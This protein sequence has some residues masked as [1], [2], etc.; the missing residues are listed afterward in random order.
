MTEQAAPK[1]LP[2]ERIA[3]RLPDW[4]RGPW[5][6]AVALV[7]GV[8]Q[9]RVSMLARQAAYSLL[10]AVPSIVILAVSLANIID[11]RTGSHL[12]D[13][14]QEVI[15]EHAPPEFQAFLSDILQHAL[16]DTSTDAATTAAIVAILIAIWG[17]AGGTGALVFACNDVYD[18]GDKRSWVLRK[19][20]TLL[21]TLFGAIIA[22]TS[23]ILFTLGERI[24]DWL[25]REFS[26]DSRIVGIL[27]SGRIVAAA[28]IFASL[29]L[30]YWV[31]PDVEKTFRWL[32]PGTAAATLA[33]ILMFSLL[34]TLLKF[35][36]PGSGYGVAGVAGGMLILLWFLYVISLIVV[37]GAVINAVLSEH[38][39]P[40]LIRFLKEHPERRIRPAAEWIQH[41][42]ERY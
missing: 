3:A 14:L 17:G 39:D 32:L 13:L 2:S 27:S 22:I 16:L 31:A 37:V 12:Y 26:A 30:L 34:D 1:P 24:A 42:P 23:L 18:V 29:F 38:F 36:S 28:L 4:L 35:I 7:N 8:Q 21:I 20:L 15:K 10:Y 19:A 25:V 5:A 6:V 40:K 33:I 41:P 9:H 11:Q